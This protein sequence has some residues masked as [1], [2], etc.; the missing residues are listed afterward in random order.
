MGF[1][2]R[3]PA[4]PLAPFV[5]LLWCYESGPTPHARERLLPTGT[6]EL[7][8]N[9]AEDE[10][11]VY[12]GEEGERCLRLAGASVAGPHGRAFIIDTAEQQC[13]AGVHFRPGGAFPFLGLPAD[14]LRDQHVSLEDLWGRAGA[15]ELRERLLA[16]PT[17]ERRLD[18]LEAALLARLG[19]SRHPA[20]G[21][22]LRAFHRVPLQATVAEVTAQV[23][24]SPRRFIQ[25]FSE[26]VGLTPKLYCRVRRFQEVLGRIRAGARLDWAGLALDCGYFD[27][28]HFGHDFR[29][30][31]GM[32]P[33]AYQALRTENTNHVPLI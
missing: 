15:A 1:Q 30:F 26:E 20:V 11:R 16:A 17:P 28:A 13:V 18:L 27:Q 8:V 4:R 25:V 6:V 22:A 19:S 10:T 24:L 31:A 12:E 7:V 2:R 21:H 29:A 9:L 32:S 14:E 3:A 33:T 5:E 23:G